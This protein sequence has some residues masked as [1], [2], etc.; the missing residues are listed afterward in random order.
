M[1]YRSFIIFIALASSSALQAA[2]V[3]TKFTIH[4]DEPSL[5]HVDVG[6]KGQSQR[7]LLAFDAPV[8]TTS[9]E[10]GK[11]SGLVIAVDTPENEP[12]VF[13]DRIVS[14]V[15]DF[16][17]A[18]TLVISGKSVY[19]YHGELEFA[20][21]VAQIRAIVGGTGKYIGARGQIS[22]TRDDDDG[23]THVI[24]LVD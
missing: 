6:Q 7:D 13:Q 2:D 10:K 23:Y 24:E 9:G 22:T 17:N 5:A 18:N 1:I 15:F 12:E 19:P 20:K 3:T 8:Q 14:M 16:G 4:Q 21:N 11:L